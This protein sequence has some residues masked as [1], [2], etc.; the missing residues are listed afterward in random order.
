MRVFD[1]LKKICFPSSSLELPVFAWSKY[2]EALDEK[3][4]RS[5]GIKK[6]FFFR[7]YSNITFRLQQ[8]ANEKYCLLNPWRL[9]GDKN[10]YVLGN[11]ACTNNKSKF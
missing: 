2:D 6:D 5:T 7:K 1:V 3:T 8:L 4:A 10:R 9:R 11:E